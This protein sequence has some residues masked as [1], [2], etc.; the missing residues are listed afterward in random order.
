MPYP[1][2]AFAEP[3]LQESRLRKACHSRRVLALCLVFFGL[4][5]AVLLNSV[6]CLG[7]SEQNL[8]VQNKEISLALQHTRPARAWQFPRQATVMR[9]SQPLASVWQSPQPSWFRQTMKP[10]AAEGFGS[11][12][13]EEKEKDDGSEDRLAA[14]EARVSTRGKKE[15]KEAYE[16]PD[17][18]PQPLIKQKKPPKEQAP[19]VPKTFPYETQ[20]VGFLAFT[21]ALIILQGLFLGLAGFLG[22]DF[23]N[24]AVTVVFPLFTPTVGL[25]LLLSSIYGVVKSIQDQA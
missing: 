9:L 14:L 16:A 10:A 23:D 20:Y 15:K 12:A 21:G 4:G 25:F 22:G 19:G 13:P 24:I 11:K 6:P 17:F 5:L 8:V 3:L 7:E 2:L 18:E 1:N